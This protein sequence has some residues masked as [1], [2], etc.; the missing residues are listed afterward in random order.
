MKMKFYASPAVELLDLYTEGVMCM[1]D[2]S[3]DSEHGGFTG[4][5]S[6]PDDLWQ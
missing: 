2:S 5:T 4:D 3:L 6:D 1:S